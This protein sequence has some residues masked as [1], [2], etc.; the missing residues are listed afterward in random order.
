MSEPNTAPVRWDQFPS[1]AFAV[2]GAM[3]GVCLIGWFLEPQQFFRSYLTAYLFALG[4]PL[5]CLA[6]LMLHHLVGGEWGLMIQRLLE[7]GVTTLPPMALL[8]L[9]VIAGM[10]ELYLWARPDAVATDPLLQQKA[11]YLN[12]PFFVLRAALYFAIWIGLG[13]FLNRW[14][15]EGERGTDA[16][17]TRRLQGLSGP[18]LVLYGLTVTFAAIDWAM[19]LEPHWYS[20]I[21]GMMFM[22]GYGLAALALM[23]FVVSW[24]SDLEPLSRVMTADHFHDL[25]NLL[26]ALVMFWAYLGFSQYLIIWMA[27]LQEEIPWYLHRTAGGWMAVAISL[28][29]F[30]F[31]LPF[32]LLLCRASKRAAGALA[33]IAALILVM[34]WVDLFWLVTPAFHPQGF[35]FHWL[36]LTTTIGVGALW[37]ALF[38]RSFQKHSLLPL[39][40]PRVTAAMAA[41][42]RA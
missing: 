13:Y 30:Q 40:D 42:K 11:A 16:T 41:V 6:L 1:H 2:G 22:L 31:I 10:S 36:D 17:L 32:F 9:P 12:A 18:G 28:L 25:G 27:N 26:F 20:T 34:R 23:I 8:F 38:V 19:S 21:Y 3:A 33:G 37:A 24:L 5:G 29:V 35:Y 39:H 7:A 14:S 15:L 4:F